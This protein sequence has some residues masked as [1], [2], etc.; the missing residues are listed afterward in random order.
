MLLPIEQSGPTEVG[1][2]ASLTVV[3]DPFVLT[4]RWLSGAGLPVPAIH[5]IDEQRQAIWLDDL[6]DIDLDQWVTEDLAKQLER[7]QSAVRLLVRF[8]RAAGQGGAPAQVV[9]RRFDRDLLLW[10]LEHYVEWRLEAQLQRTLDDAVRAE[11]RRCFEAL[12]EATLEM[13]E[14]VIHRDFQSHNI[15][16]HGEP[17]SLTLLDFQ[18]AMRGPLVYDAVALLRDSYVHIAPLDLSE[19]VASYA[20]QLRDAGVIDQST[21]AAVPRWFA[22]QTVQRK[23]K[24]A[25]RFVFIERIRKNPSF[26]KYI[27]VSLQ[28]VAEAL[29][30]LPELARLR[31]LL[32]E[33]DPEI[34]RHTESVPE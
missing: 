12:V 8:T 24:D 30:Q 34:A 14:V 28:Y 15:M 26:L 4:Q 31:A 22:L 13:P 20:H 10:E 17:P 16:V 3:D 1:G 27:P 2:P 33:L 25:G 21:M 11:L 7:Y 23:L 19:L 29:V 5:G 18:D 32:C 9:A 6:G